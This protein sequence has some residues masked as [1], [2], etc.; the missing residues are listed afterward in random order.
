MNLLTFLVILATISLSAVAQL[1]LKLGV[2]N[3]RL[4]DAIAGGP[5]AAAQAVVTSPTI[6]GGL[7]LYFSAALA[8]LWVLTRAD[9][10]VAYPF[11]G[12]SFILTSGLGWLVLNE[13]V[14]LMR[15][16]GTLLIVFGCVMVARSA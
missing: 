2:G 13:D 1:V 11:V 16:A 3:A 6:I 5:L 14:T 15:M 10:S 7:T 9:L 12:L 8:W 4:G